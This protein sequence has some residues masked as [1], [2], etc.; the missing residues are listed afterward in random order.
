MSDVI[1][2]E[3]K[4]REK[5]KEWLWPKRGACSPSCY[6]WRQNIASA[7]IILLVVVPCWA[8]VSYGGA[9]PHIHGFVTSDKL[10]SLNEKVDYLT[11]DRME[12]RLQDKFW[13]SC[14]V[15]GQTRRRLLAEIG[16]LQNK[17]KSMFGDRFWMGPCK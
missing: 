8:F 2:A 17:Y 6:P 13:M 16:A 11:Q 3:E 9:E 5:L 12:Q 14:D 4:V 7:V 1:N 15:T 10:A